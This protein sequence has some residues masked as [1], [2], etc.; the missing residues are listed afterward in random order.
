MYIWP[1]FIKHFQWDILC[2]C[3][4][5]NFTTVSFSKKQQNNRNI[6]EYIYIYAYM[7]LVS[8]IWLSSWTKFRKW[9]SHHPHQEPH[10]ILIHIFWQK[11]NLCTFRARGSNYT[12]VL[13]EKDWYRVIKEECY[14]PV[15]LASIIRVPRC[16]HLKKSGIILHTYINILS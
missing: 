15:Q 10:Y 4:D 14:T 5:F 13:F 9:L 8:L 16:G 3:Y 7:P 6:W 2:T 1:C 12:W 11:K